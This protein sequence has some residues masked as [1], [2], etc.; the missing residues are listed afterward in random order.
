M[1]NLMR[2]LLAA[3]PGVS[4]NAAAAGDR[5]VAPDM[6]AL[7]AAVA[8]LTTIVVSCRSWVASCSLD[9]GFPTMA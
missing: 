1:L 2:L 6:V 4:A 9:G 8:K 7:L 5:L 3:R